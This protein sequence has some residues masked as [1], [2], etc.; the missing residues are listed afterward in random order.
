ME[1]KTIILR[2]KKE[3]LKKCSLRGLEKRDDFIFF[4][5]PKE[6]TFNLDG[7]VLLS[8]D[9]E[10]LKKED[11]NKGLFLIDSTWRYLEK[12]MKIIP[13]DI[14]KR[15]I[16]KNYKTAYPRYQ[17]DCQDPETGLAS[18]EALYIAFKILNKNSDNLL[19]NY[20][21]R[22]KFLEMNNL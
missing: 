19:D 13:I 22:E 9:G 17:T 21:W 16:P 7:Y 3:N 5:Y 11:Q 18:I 14:E 1:K 6:I 20:H 2:H 8:Q 12:I 15:S 4:T 10:D